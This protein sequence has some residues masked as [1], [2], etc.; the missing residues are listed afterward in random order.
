GVEDST[1]A[2]ARV[3]G[4][5]GIGIDV[6]N[7][8]ATTTPTVKVNAAGSIVSTGNVSFIATSNSDADS[9]SDS[10]QV[11]ILLSVS[12]LNANV[13]VKPTVSLNVDS[14]MAINAGGALTLKAQHGQAPVTYS[15]GTFNAGSNTAVNVAD[16]TIGFGA[17]HGLQTGDNV[18]YRANGGTPVGGLQD[19][20]RVGI[21]KVD[22]QKLAFGTEVLSTSVSTARDE[23][24]F[25]AQHN[26]RDGDRVIYQPTTGNAII[27]G[28]TSG[29]T[30]IVRVM[31]TQTIK[32]V[33][34]N[35]VPAAAKNLTGASI[36]NDVITINGHGFANGQAVTYRAAKATVFRNGAVD[37]VGDAATLTADRYNFANNDNIYLESHGLITGDEIV[38][39]ASAG[40]PISG[41]ESGRRYFVIRV[42]ANEIKLASSLLNATGDSANNV[43]VTAIPLSAD[44]TKSGVDLS[45]RRVVD[46]PIGG[47]ED[48]VTYYIAN[49]TT[50]SFKLAR[51]SDGSNLVSLSGVDAASNKVLTGTS[52]IGTEGIDFLSPGTG[53]QRLT[54]DITGLGSGTA[55]LFGVGSALALAGAPAGDGVATASATG[56]GGGI[57]RVTGANTSSKSEPT[58]SVTIGATGGE[59]SVFNASSIVVAADAI[60][61]VS[62][63]AASSGGGLI[64][65][66]TTNSNIVANSKGTVAVNNARFFATNNLSV[67]AGSS[68]NSSILSDSNGGGLVDVANANTK[69]DLNYVA[70]VDLGA[71]VLLQADGDV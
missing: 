37:V 59:N 68:I 56:S 22:D 28:L 57:L 4:V 10:T 26:F 13:S 65:V 62:S 43:P 25:P 35:A 54:L 63:S 61:N 52:K 64:S 3:I 21:I 6:S 5:G 29:A 41:L 71:D 53:S 18:E 49:S 30:Y 1:R 8:D 34:P 55:Q 7:V 67:T 46:L 36:A 47:L 17:S 31:D 45:I 20:R 66:G 33:N 27:G 14:G 44:T 70:H 58:V 40:E 48:G 19:G 15:D 39:T 32:L 2:G 9:A 51:N 69:T 12:Q 50:N 11:G 24:R 16:N 38:Y 42:N 60:A 23:I